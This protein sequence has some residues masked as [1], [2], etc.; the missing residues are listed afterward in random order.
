MA[1]PHDPWHRIVNVHWPD[2]GE[3]PQP[4]GYLVEVTGGFGP[5][6]FHF[7]ECS[8]GGLV[9]EP[10]TEFFW[11][12]AAGSA[13][14]GGMLLIAERNGN[15]MSNPT[16][17][18][19][20]S[21]RGGHPPPLVVDHGQFAFR[22]GVGDSFAV[23]SGSLPNITVALSMQAC[24]GPTGCNGQLVIRHYTGAF[25]SV[26]SY[27]MDF[28]GATA[29]MISGSGPTL[30]TRT[31]VYDGPVSNSGPGISSSWFVWMRETTEGAP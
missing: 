30:H 15:E 13:T 16:I 22:A 7:V 27:S 24:S 20:L 2:D 23:V 3:P 31:F 17:F 5:T 9:D 21:S 14:I 8:G 10:F 11:S 6:G 19:S 26:G 12:G 18:G 1:F 28:S 29:E 4:W 25:T